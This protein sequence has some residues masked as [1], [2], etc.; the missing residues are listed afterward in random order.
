MLD[1]VSEHALPLLC[2]S[3]RSGDPLGPEEDLVVA[4]LGVMNA[5]LVRRTAMDRYPVLVN[6][7]QAG[8]R[9]VALP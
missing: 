1:R 6:V 8:G 2:Y 4:V 7:E 3:R 9:R 5:S